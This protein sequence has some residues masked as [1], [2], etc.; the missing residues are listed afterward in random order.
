[1]N[2]SLLKC[3]MVAVLSD[4]IKQ[5]FFKPACKILI[6][7]IDICLNAAIVTKVVQ[8]IAANRAP[9]SIGCCYLGMQV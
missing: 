4:Y 1:M 8:I 3:D 2:R 6:E 5:Y 7:Y 9:V